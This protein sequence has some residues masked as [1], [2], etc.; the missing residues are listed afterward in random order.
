MYG[1]TFAPALLTA[2]RVAAGMT[3]AELATAAGLT[4]RS[5]N[6]FERGHRRHPWDSSIA[7]LATAL[8]CTTDDLTVPTGRSNGAAA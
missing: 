8:G 7:K 2:R 4:K 5:I 6:R 3:Q 1:R